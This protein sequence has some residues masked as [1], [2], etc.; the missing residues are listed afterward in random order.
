M[1]KSEKSVDEVWLNL[2]DFRKGFM[3]SV[4]QNTSSEQ[5]TSNASRPSNVSS[6]L[7]TFKVTPFQILYP[8]ED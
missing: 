7:S 3:P 1:Q 2:I 6:G 8:P 5:S 4:R